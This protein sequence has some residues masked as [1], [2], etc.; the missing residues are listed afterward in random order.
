MT[1]RKL[2]EAI[3]M[4]SNRREFTL[5][6]AGAAGALALGSQPTSAQD[7]VEIPEGGTLQVAI[8][9]EPPAVAD[10]VFT[11]ATVTNNVSQQIFETLFAF[12]SSFTPQPM[13]IEDYEGSED[14][15]EFTFKLRTDVPF[16]NGDP[17]TAEDVVAS[18]NRW[19]E[20]N[21]RGKLIYGR[22]DSIEATDASTVKMVF[23]Q[24][25]GVLPSFLARSEA[26]ITPA[27]VA[28]AA[29]TDQ[30][31]EDQLIGTGPFKFIEH[32]VDRYLRLGR[33]DDYAARND[34]PNGL[35]GK[36]IPYLDGIDFV[37][38][39]DESVRAN[40]LITGEYHFS[41]VL[42][43]DLHEMLEMDPAVDPIIVQPYYWYSPHFNKAQGLFTN[44]AL[45]QAVQLCFSESEAMLAGF[46][47]EEFVRFDP[48]VCGEETPWY[49]T[50]GADVYDRVDLEQARALLKEGGYNGETVRWL[51]TREYPY[52]F[53]M[54]DF[55]RQG[56][57][58]IGMKVELIVSDWATL[59]Q[60]RAK[61]DAY[62]IFLTGHS[63]YSHPATQP[64]NDPAWP[65]FWESEAK[66][67]L[68]NE[69]VAET[70][71]EKLKSIIDE[72]TALIWDEMPFVKCG[73]NFVLRGIRQEVVGYNNMPDWFFWNLGLNG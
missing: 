46:G 43:S 27:S 47:Q 55:T 44:P 21:G 23:N 37:P 52:N 22:M 16:H 9:G 57:E 7:E 68:V 73:D 33:F 38:V 71:L 5:G 6:M 60:N 51:A 15:L 67:T 2:G 14:G 1:S 29:G 70:D 36:R 26:M 34:P 39:P 11:T 30:I 65:G 49:S 64:F 45:R 56:M 63:Q 3:P 25:S 42:P 59:V 41:D 50:A 72:Y 18:L 66:D 62:E 12:D 53:L 61:P 58:A 28:E 10:A 35:A 13:L 48:S 32:Q 8:I 54:A 24:P 40:G 20:I 19:G 69:M 17:M 31:P 4:R